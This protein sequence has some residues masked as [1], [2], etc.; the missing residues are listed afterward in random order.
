MKGDSNIFS[1]FGQVGGGQ[2]GSTAVY[3]GGGGGQQQ[4]SNHHGEHLKVDGVDWSNVL[5][6]LLD[7]HAAIQ[8]VSL[9]ME[10]G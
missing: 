6:P 3:S 1:S 2:G 9:C 7:A 5:N 4:Q 8:L 10:C